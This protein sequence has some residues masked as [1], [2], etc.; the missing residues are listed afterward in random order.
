MKKYLA[1]IFALCLCIIMA[2]C[3][4][5]GIGGGS[6]HTL[7]PVAGWWTKPYGYEG[8]TIPYT[9]RVDAE[10]EA[11]ISYDEYGNVSDEYPCRYDEAGFTVDCG[12][13]FGSVTYILEG[14]TLLDEEGAVQYVRCEPIGPDAA[15]FSAEELT[16]VWNKNGETDEGIECLILEKDGYNT[17]QYGNVTGNG[18]WSITKVETLYNDISYTGPAVEFEV[19]SGFPPEALWVLEEGNILYDDF[20]G[21]FYIKAGI[22]DAA[23]QSLCEK[24][25]LVRDS[26]EC[27]EDGSSVRF[28]FF[29]EVI[30]GSGSTMESIGKWRFT[31]GTLRLEYAD[32]S[33]REYEA[34][35]EMSIDYGG[36]AF[37]RSE[38][39]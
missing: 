4:S 37:A 24:Y 33:V 28:A 2:A 19:E 17:R 30:L 15:P 10:S 8:F 6:E 23:W 32:G 38:A 13:V 21:E 9:F 36:K 34:I 39:W 31:D 11:V 18:S 22:D 3:T 1:L 35:D 14:D 12:D 25:A 20:H 26:W 7:D 16:G 27:A 5:G 29:G